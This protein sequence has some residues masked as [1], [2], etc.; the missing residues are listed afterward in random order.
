MATRELIEQGQDLIAQIDYL[1]SRYYDPAGGYEAI[2]FQVIASGKVVLDAQK[3]I[4]EAP[5]DLKSGLQA[6][7][8]AALETAFSEIESYIDSTKA[9]TEADLASLGGT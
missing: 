3:L 5:T 2:T 4:D 7:I 1:G 8:T 9:S 6:A